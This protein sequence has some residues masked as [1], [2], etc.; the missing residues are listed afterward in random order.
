MRKRADFVEASRFWKAAQVWFRFKQRLGLT[1]GRDIPQLPDAHYAEH[2]SPA[3]P[4]AHWL[5]ENALRENDVE[6]LRGMVGLLPVRPSFAFIP[7]AAGPAEPA[8]IAANLEEQVYGAWSVAPPGDVNATLRATSSDFVAIVEAGVVLTPDALFEVA[9]ALAKNPTLDVIYSDH[10]T[11]T[12]AGARVDPHFKPDWSPETLLSRMYLGPLVFY[13]RSAV[14]DA[15]G[16][17]PEFGTAALFDLAL[18]VTEA[19]D[20]IA[21]L[22]RILYHVRATQP[23]PPHDGERAQAAIAEAL[24]RRGE[25]GRTSP[26]AGSAGS[27]HIRY[28]LE[29]APRV[30]VILPTRDNA[31]DLSTALRSLFE[32]T[33]YSN[34]GVLLIDNG[35]KD[36]AT[37]R[38][39]EEWSARE[40]A[41][42]KVH[43]L[44]I[45]FNFSKLNNEAARLADAEFL[46]FLNDDTEILTADWI[47]AMLEQARRPAIGAVGARL[48]YR[49]GSV[50]HAGVILGI[51]GIAGHAHR[52]FPGDA[53]GYLGSLQAI[54][55]YSAVTAACLMM[56]RAVFDEVG[57]FDE[58]L[59]I[60]FN[61][62]DLCLRVRRAN[63]RIVYLP[64][65][66]LYHS[67]SGSRGD[68][69]NVL[70]T[71]VRVREQGLMH[72]R[73]DVANYADPYYNA[74][75]TLEAEDFSV[76]H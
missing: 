32:R 27:Y 6:R 76:R 4:Y 75:L 68:A 1:L 31:A 49:D 74:N 3:D 24:V 65:V 23:Q 10:D 2:V 61:D 12:P 51:R 17:R 16:L 22:P 63:Y 47:E 38:L 14:V 66:V 7:V 9:L 8:R 59:A 11:L 21:H 42:L 18:R 72:E 52:F 45:P 37:L 15:G 19:T 41:R 39:L 28:A 50:Q 67:E 30:R 69:D 44:D 40:P 25:S 20:R 36:P 56:R 33:T 71:M 54:T 13:R 34:F 48:L 70:K 26:V 73:W 35:S 43:R 55:N 64:H 5:A 53:Q 58:D 29:S 62:I 46:L 60:E 57:G